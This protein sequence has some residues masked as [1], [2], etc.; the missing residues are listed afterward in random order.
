ML[1]CS[2]CVAQQDDSAV[3]WNTLNP[4]LEFS[5]LSLHSGT[6]FSS[7]MILLRADS[8]YSLR[9]IR[10]T[11]FGWNRASVKALCKAAGADAC[12]NANFFDEQG[13]ALGLVVSRGIIYNK[14]HHGGGTLTGVLYSTD[15]E[16][17]I[18]HRD[19]FSFNGALEAIQAGP[20]LL[21]DG[22]PIEGVKDS[23]SSS[24][25]SGVCIDAN[26]RLVLFRVNAGVFGGSLN[27]LQKN[28]LRPDIGCVD[29]L[30]FDGG[31]SSQL[32]ISAD[33]TS[34]ENDESLPGEDDVPVAMG[35]FK[36]PQDS[37]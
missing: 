23:S 32:F 6:V 21:V 14:M 29:A 10:A 19:S 7:S 3:A 33:A 8:S 5:R 15:K 25:L 28:L 2:P 37:K 20:R 26:R 27:G 4:G 31:G 24:N 34:L 13:R 9:A 16:T 17:R 12:I 1:W 11:Q 36:K 35:F 30:N 18:V 22:K